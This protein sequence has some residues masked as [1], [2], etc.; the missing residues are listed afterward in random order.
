MLPKYD[1]RACQ[2]TAMSPLCFLSH[3]QPSRAVRKNSQVGSS[4]AH[5]VVHRPSQLDRN[6]E[7][8]PHK[9]RPSEDEPV[10]G[11][12]IGFLYSPFRLKS[13]HFLLVN[14]Q[15]NRISVII[16]KHKDLA[17]HFGAAIRPLSYRARASFSHFQALTKGGLREVKRN[18]F[19]ACHIHGVER[20]GGTPGKIG[21]VKPRSFQ[22]YYASPPK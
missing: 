9:R 2:S 1:I 11:R 4:S 8:A 18:N 10:G 15:K 13:F 21:H 6:S 16:H 7:E 5:W 19:P 17:R 12:L 20:V 22:S 14:V 3:Y